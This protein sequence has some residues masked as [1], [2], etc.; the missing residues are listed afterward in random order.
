MTSQSPA[1]AGHRLRPSQVPV[2][3]SSVAPALDPVNDDFDRPGRDLGVLRRP[4][5]SLLG[6]DFASV[7]IHEDGLAE[8]V[9][10][11][12]VTLGDDIHIPPAERSLS[13]SNGGWL[14]AHELVHV[15][16]QRRPAGTVPRGISELEREAD[17]VATV[18]GAGGKAK[19]GGRVAADGLVPQ[20]KPKLAP[21]P[22]T[23]NILYVGMNNADPEIKGLLGRYRSGSSVS[24]AVVKATKEESKATIGGADTFDLTTDPGIADL[25]SKLTPDSAK[26]QRLVEIFKVQRAEDRDDLAH[27]AKVYADTESDGKDRMTRVVLSG[28]SKGGEVFGS[29]GEVLFSALVDLA[30]VFPQAAN[31]T[32]HLL[33]AGCHT[34]DEGTILAYY[35]M[36][37]PSLLTV[38]AWWDACPTGPGAVSAIEKWAGLTEHG[39]TTLP[40]QGSGIAT[41][42]GGI[43]AGSPSG[44]APKADLLIYIHT[45]DPELKKYFDGERK[46]PSPHDGWLS[47]Y[48]DRVNRAAHRPDLSDA[49][50]RDMQQRLEQAFRLRYWRQVAKS[51]WVKNKD[52][53]T[54]GYGNAP[55][56]DYASLDRKDTLQAISGF[57]AKSTASDPDKSDAGRLLDALKNLDPVAIPDSMIVE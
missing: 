53:I 10:A 42:S 29:G 50:R 30:G 3:N 35:V 45:T 21:P 17:E 1:R 27:V 41:W 26:Q 33:V 49:E 38:W 51:F 12:A 37:Y 14:I 40:K 32:K 57:P 43:Y 15:I 9:G 24:V 25:A 11:R 23:G 20:L 6:H 4:M 7:R 5:E 16:Q 54:R 39:E 36:A 46:D 8:A 52:A 34:G 19:V 55:V 48:Y 28:H 2:V 31:Q 13:S 56:P 47:V 22:P 44:Q 18:V